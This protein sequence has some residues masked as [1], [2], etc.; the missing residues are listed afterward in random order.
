[1][2]IHS[3][4]KTHSYGKKE[5]SQSDFSIEC[6][7]QLAYQAAPKILDEELLFSIL[8]KPS[9]SSK[10]HKLAPSAVLG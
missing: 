10:H 2:V 7:V 3:F 8:Q 9:K 6:G 5:T 1:M 4:C